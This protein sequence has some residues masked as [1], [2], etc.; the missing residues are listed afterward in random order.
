M[1]EQ[2]NDFYGYKKSISRVAATLGIS[3]TLAVGAIAGVA[4]HNSNKDFNDTFQKGYSTVEENTTQSSNLSYQDFKDNLSRYIELSNKEDLSSKEKA[5]IKD[6]RSQIRNSPEGIT[7]LSLEVLKTKIAAS[8]GIDDYKRI[9]VHNNSTEVSVD[10][11]H[12]RNGYMEKIDICVDGEPAYSRNAFQNLADGEISVNSNSIP[13]EV[14]DV[15]YV[16]SDAQGKDDLKTSIKSLKSSLDLDMKD[17]TFEQT[18]KNDL[19]ER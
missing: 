3:A 10:Q 16:I 6:L 8:L 11:Y 17:I 4:T 18:Q 1:I 2:I 13:E 7:T 14:L 5:E 12:S 15:I 19:D 9:T